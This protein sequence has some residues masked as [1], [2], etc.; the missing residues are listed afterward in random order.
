MWQVLLEVHVLDPNL[1]A[2]PKSRGGIG[3][4]LSGPKKPPILAEK[5]FQVRDLP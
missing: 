3:S 4:L 2:T 1:A 5:V